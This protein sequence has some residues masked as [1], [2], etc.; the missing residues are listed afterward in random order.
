MLSTNN[1]LPA[2]FPYPKSRP[3][4]SDQLVVQQP[5]GNVPQQKPIQRL[6]SL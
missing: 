2:L 1:I 3:H 5:F 6:L 4:P